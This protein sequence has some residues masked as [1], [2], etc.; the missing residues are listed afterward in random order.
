[1]VESHRIFSRG[2]RN[3]LRAALQPAMLL[4][5]L[6]IPALW[7]A[8]T[9]VLI[10]EHK[11]TLESAIQQGG[12]LA[13]LF[14]QDT[15]A[16]LEGVDRTLLLLRQE[17]ERD[18]DHFDL[19]RLLKRATFTD[20]LTIHFAIAG[21]DG[22]AKAPL[23]PDDA[24]ATANFADRGWFQKQRAAAIDELV[25]SRP[26]SGRLSKKWSIIL[27]RRLRDR[28]GNFAGIIAASVDPEYLGNFY[29]TIDVGAHG[30]VILRDRDGVILASGGTAGP[31]MGRQVMQPALREAL[32]HS[33]IG[34][35]W[36]GGA[37]DGVNRL[38]SYR[39]SEKLPIMTMVG[40]AEHDIFEPYERLQRIFISAA[41]ILTILLI[42]GFVA[43]LRR[44]LPSAKIS[45]P[46]KNCIW[47][48]PWRTCRKA[49]ACST[50][51][52]GSSCAISNTSISTTWAKS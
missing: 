26:V 30:S 32:A 40:L 34:Y 39:A 8:L 12:N 21:R 14:E 2:Q 29:K 52:S 37:V 25:V 18:P 49:F 24:V 23:S 19:N 6:M 33:P 35:Y 47:M 50:A 31:A 41:G 20:D 22:D 44:A 16:M 38:V 5:G 3:W 51:I 48:P 9:S 11:R 42:V 13:R 46:G 43:S 36:G 28:D 45:L 7:V 15:V 4:Y 1:M 27:S 10:L 17:Y